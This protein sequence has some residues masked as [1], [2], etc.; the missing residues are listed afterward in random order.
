MDMQKLKQKYEQ[1]HKLQ[2]ASDLIKIK[3]T[4]GKHTDVHRLLEMTRPHRLDASVLIHMVDCQY[5]I[6]HLMDRFTPTDCN[7]ALLKAVEKSLTQTVV[8]LLEFVSDVVNVAPLTSLAIQNNDAATLK[9]LATQI[10]QEEKMRL[11]RR[12]CFKPSTDTISSKRSLSPCE[13]A[14]VLLEHTPTPDIQYLMEHANTPIFQEACHHV[15]M[16]RQHQT[17]TNTVELTQPNPTP[18]RKI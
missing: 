7:F 12:S 18:K 6:E 11:L 4:K 17:L 15:Y 13:I 3:A 5:P 10:S 9:V 1:A 14:E 16:L 8:F 2:R